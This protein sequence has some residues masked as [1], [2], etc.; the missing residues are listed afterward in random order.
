M[1]FFLRRTFD[2]MNHGSQVPKLYLMNVR[3]G[4]AKICVSG[5]WKPVESWISN[6]HN[7]ALRAFAA[8]FQV[9]TGR[10]Y[11]RRGRSVHYFDR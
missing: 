8:S 5:Q 7:P 11:R 10:S 1:T 6:L 4:T 3:V 9:Q 2:W